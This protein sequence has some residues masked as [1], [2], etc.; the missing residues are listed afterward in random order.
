M[1]GLFLNIIRCGECRWI[2]VSDAEDDSVSCVNRDC[3]EYENKYETP[4]IE[5][6]VKRA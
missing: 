5:L 6:E 4:A 3:V 1:R 2:L